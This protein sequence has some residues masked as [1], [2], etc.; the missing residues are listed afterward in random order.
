MKSL[1]R[2]VR[3]VW[4][5]PSRGPDAEYFDEAHRRSEDPWGHLSND[6]ER[7]RYAWMIEALDGRRFGRAFEVGCSI[8]AFTELLADHCDEL[9]AVDISQEAVDSARERLAERPGVSVECRT[10]PADMPAGPF[11]LIVCADVLMYWNAEE[12]RGALKAFESSLTPEGVLLAVSY[13]PKVR[14]QPLQGDAVHDLLTA[15]TSLTLTRHEER[16][17]HRLDRFARA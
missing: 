3:A 11:D 4:P 5:A 16:G 10:L 7:Q 15:E 9:L 14:I 12:L 2:L 8:G 1:R 6:Y 17:D 13:R